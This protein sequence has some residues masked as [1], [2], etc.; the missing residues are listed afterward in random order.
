MTGS[1]GALDHILLVLI[2][3]VWP[4]AEWLYSYP[5]AMRAI[6]S[7]IRGARMRLYRNILL[8]EWGFTAAV[9][10]RWLARGR[11]WSVLRL[12]IGTPLQTTIGVAFVALAFALFWSQRRSI[13]P[14]PEKYEMVRNKFKTAS[15]LVPHTIEELR[16]FAAV[17]I[18]A[19]I[20]EEILFR[21]FVMW[22]VASWFQGGWLAAAATV[23]ISSVLFGFAH[24][25]LGMQHVGSTTIGGFVFAII[26]LG[27]GSLWA[28]IIVHAVADLSSGELGYYAFRQTGEGQAATHG[29]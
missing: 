20:C 23:A 8:L 17:S 21:G 5:R 18:T 26:A 13:L 15:G 11:P 27:A 22:Y 19:G 3:G 16:M 24:I 14:R 29:E 4:L 10:A 12:C 6:D 2:V 1:P 9:V 28:A 7:G 25:Y